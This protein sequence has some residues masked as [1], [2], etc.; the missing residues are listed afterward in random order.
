MNGSPRTEVPGAG[1]RLHG[2]P[3]LTGVTDNPAFRDRCARALDLPDHFGRNGDAL[4]DCL[5]HL[6]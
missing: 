3:D 6:P 5:P 4:A 1:D 2:E